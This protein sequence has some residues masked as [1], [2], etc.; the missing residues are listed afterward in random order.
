MQGRTTLH[1]GLYNPRTEVVQPPYAGGSF[2]RHTC[3]IT[4]A[5]Q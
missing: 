5:V 2:C 4:K 1:A 3:L